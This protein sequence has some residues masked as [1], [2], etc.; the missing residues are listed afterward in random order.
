MKERAE[1]RSGWIVAA[2]GACAFLFKLFLAVRTYGTN[3]V[4]SYD[5][6]SVWSRYLGVSLYHLDPLFNHPPSMIHLLHGLSWLGRVTAL[7]FSFWLRLPAILA[8]AANL[9]LIWKLLGARVREQ[10]IFWALLL[11]AAAPTLILVSGFHGN[12]DSVVMFFVLLSVYLVE[13]DASVWAAGAALGLAHCVKIYP[14]IAAPAILL[15]LPSWNRR[16]KFCAAAG[17][18]LLVAWSPFV[19]QDPRIVIGQVFGYRS[20]YGVW[21]LSYILDTLTARVPSLTPLNAAYERL[22]AYIALGLVCLV[23]F[24]LNS[25]RMSEASQRPQLFSQVGLVFLLFLSVSSGFGVQY[26]AWL[27]PWVVEQ[28]A[29]A[30]VLFFTTS[31]IFLFLVYNL[32]AQGLPWYLADSYNIG[33][34]VGYYDYSQLLCWISLLMVLWVAWTRL[35]PSPPAPIG[36]RWAAGVLAAVAIF[37]IVPPQLPT[38]E[39]AGGKYEDAVRSINARSYLDLAALLSDRHRYQDSIEAAREALALTPESADEADAIIAG[40]EAALGTPNPRR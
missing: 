15:Y 32:W 24:R 3:D 5:Q 35:F 1:L 6:F 16:I 12:T 10:S 17:L 23:S 22:G 19:F 33:T 40:D 8:D 11:L 2:A 20:S 7:P 27:A 25:G 14:L 4:Y 18:V 31:G 26:L 38:P 36:W 13:K 28:G 39:P 29:L 9:W 21:G 37:A 30:A 34:F